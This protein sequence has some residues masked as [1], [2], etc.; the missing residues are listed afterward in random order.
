M[1]WCGTEDHHSGHGELSA[2]GAGSSL[3]VGRLLVVGFDSFE[4]LRLDRFRLALNFL[5]QPGNHFALIDDH[6]VQLIELVF[7]MG[8]GCFKLLQPFL[9]F[10]LHTSACRC[11]GDRQ[12]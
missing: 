8:D 5:L 2:A 3:I 9:S 12:Q 1:I 4:F 10:L 11:D 6:L 7:Q